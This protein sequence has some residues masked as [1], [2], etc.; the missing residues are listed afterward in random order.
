MKKHI[1]LLPA[2]NMKQNK[3]LNPAVYPHVCGIRFVQAVTKATELGEA[4]EAVKVVNTV[5]V[6]A[7][8]VVVEAVGATTVRTSPLILVID[9]QNI[10]CE[11]PCFME[12]Y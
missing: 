6:R 5:A 7:K 11:R 8:A 12:I 9:H 2:L 1:N 4:I 10:K 3:S